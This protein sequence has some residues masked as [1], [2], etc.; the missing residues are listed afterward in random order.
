MSLE[1]S[2]FS[3]SS[4]SDDAGHTPVH[5]LILDNRQ[6]TRMIFEASVGSQQS[7]VNNEVI[8][9]RQGNFAVGIDDPGLHRRLLRIWGVQGKW[10]IHNVGT[11][12]PVTLLLPAQ[13]LWTE[14]HVTLP[15]APGAELSLSAGTTTINFETQLRSYELTAEVISS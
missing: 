9:G 5:R 12:I 4:G 14:E 10:F 6:G 15:L 2:G 3:E 7:Q 13:S 11:H 1:F 8:I